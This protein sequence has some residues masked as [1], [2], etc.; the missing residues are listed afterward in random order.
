MTNILVSDIMTRNPHII[1]PDTSLLECIKK[2]LKYKVGSLNIVDK[3][4]RLVGFISQRDV[5][6]A[7]VKKA[8]LSKTKAI[9]ISPKKLITISPS[10]TIEDA[11]K[12]INEFK[13]YRLPVVSEGNL[14]GM[15]TIRDIL[16]FYPDLYSQISE[17]GYIR[18]E[19][20]K[21]K[22]LGKN[23]RNKMI[24]DGICGECG[25]RSTLYNEDGIWVCASCSSSI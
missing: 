14:V 11:I 18:E 3:N 2:F 5:L 12:K 20:D 16:T 24:I 19:E 10:A 25:K 21:L 23:E 8:N 22:R 7:I 1:K 9:D 6:W 17:I 4:H 15:L 13:I